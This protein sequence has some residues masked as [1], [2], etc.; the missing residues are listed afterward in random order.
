MSAKLSTGASPSR[1]TNDNTALDGKHDQP[2]DELMDDSQALEQL[3]AMDDS[4]YQRLIQQEMDDPQED[5]P[6]FMEVKD[7]IKELVRTG[8]IDV[9]LIDTDNDSELAT[10]I[11]EMEANNELPAPSNDPEQKDDIPDQK[12]TLLKKIRMTWSA[13]YGVC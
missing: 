4:E 13:K 3:N 6:S 7:A 9:S 1:Q 12:Q 8:D 10:I 5:E 2:D 11:R